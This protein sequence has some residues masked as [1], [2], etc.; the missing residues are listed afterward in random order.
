MY[1]VRAATSADAHAVQDIFAWCIATADWLPEQVRA[2]V[3]FAHVSAGEVVHVAVAHN[4]AVLGF[5]S[6][7]TPESFVHHLYVHPDAQ[8]CGIGRLL[9]SSLEQWLCVPWRLKCVRANQRAL[10]FYLG[11]GWREVACG[12][13]ED[14]PYAVLEWGDGGP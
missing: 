10:D 11:L 12:E 4:G 2:A 8:G 3:D 6:V 5:V 7:F 14:G 9:L 1:E 13:S